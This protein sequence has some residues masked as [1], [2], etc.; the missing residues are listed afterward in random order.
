MKNQRTGLLFSIIPVLLVILEWLIANQMFPLYSGPLEYDMDPAYQYLFNAVFLLNGQPP[1]HIDHPGTPLQVLCA[2]VIYCTWS[3]LS[4]FNVVNDQLVLSVAKTPELYLGIISSV[5]VIIH[6]LAVRYLGVRIFQATQNIGISLFCQFATLFSSILLF[7]I[8][9]LSPESLLIT[10]TT[11]LLAIFSPL[12]FTSNQANGKD[13]TSTSPVWAGL[14][15]GVGV[16]VKIN[17]LPVLGLLFLFKKKKDFFTSLFYVVI[18]AFLGVLPIISKI[19]DLFRWI[20]NVATHSGVHGSGQAGTFVFT[21]F[22]WHA[23]EMYKTFTFFYLV[24]AITVLVFLFK[25]ISL[26]FKQSTVLF[27][28]KI[29]QEENAVRNKKYGLFSAQVAF[30]FS[31]ICIVQTVFVLK[32]PGL[33]YMVPVLPIAVIGFAWFIQQLFNLKLLASYAY[34]AGL[35]LFLLGFAFCI[36]VA[37]TTLRKIEK[38]RFEQNLALQ[39][40]NQEISNYPGAIIISTYRSTLPEFALAFGLAPPLAPNL[41]SSLNPLFNNFYMWDGGI[42]KLLRYGEPMISLSHLQKQIDSGQT[43]LLSTPIRYP[44]LKA[45]T[46]ESLIDGPVQQLYKVTNTVNELGN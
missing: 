31:L 26:G 39:K 11:L 46:L 16:V 42:K 29:S 6:A 23:T 27:G 14:L 9:F 40:V 3:I 44:D 41:G 19:P 35:G 5:L 33:Y 25:L 17:F 4:L 8:V 38:A 37:N 28:A 24:L 18:G 36:D 15:C 13:K 34:L 10:I 32:H 21:N 30:V 43:V 1:F 7:R 45:F 22:H 20:L 12:I 2:I